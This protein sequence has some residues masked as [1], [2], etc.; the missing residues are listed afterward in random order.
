MTD[1]HVWGIV[2]TRAM[3]VHWTLQELGLTYGTTPIRTRTPEQT[4]PAYRAVN[5]LHKIPTLEIDGVRYSESGAIALELATRFRDRVDLWPEAER[6]RVLE[7]CFYVAM[8]LDATSLYIIRR[9]GDLA[10][11]YGEAPAAVAGAREYWLKQAAKAE[12]ALA[13]GRPWLLGETFSVADIMLG[14]CLGWAGRRG[15]AVPQILQE[16][17]AR[18]Q[19]RPARQRADEANEGR[20]DTAV[21]SARRR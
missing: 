3:R 2:S 19:T 13:D 14:S 4:A 20:L 5:P 7:W 21:G 15:V 1:I 9:H 12:A 18:L 11:T 6:A 16:Y 8:E 10:E 17:D